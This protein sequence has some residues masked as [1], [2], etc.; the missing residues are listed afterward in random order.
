MFSTYQ[1]LEM[2]A[3]IQMLQDIAIIENNKI[4]FNNLEESNDINYIKHLLEVTD[5]ALVII[6]RYERAPL[7]IFNNYFPLLEIVSKKGVLSSLELYETIRLNQTIKENKRLLDILKKE[8]IA[9]QY[10]EKLVDSLYLIT[11]LDERLNKSIDEDG[12]VL[13]DAS[14]LLKSIRNKLKNIDNKIRTKLNEILARDTKK[15]SE[16]IV[17]LRNDRYCLAVKAEYKN[18]FKGIV[19]DVSGSLQTIYIEPDAVVEL[20]MEK[21]R[22]IQ[23]EKMEIERILRSLSNE[24]GDNHLILENNFKI[25]LEIDNI[26]SRAL[27]AKKM[28]ASKQNIN[29]EGRLNI[30]NARHPLLK[31]KKVIPNNISFSEK[32]HGIIITGPNTG[33]KT[34]LLKTVGLLSL[35]TKYGL[36]IPADSSSDIMIFDQIFCD[37]GDD[38]S[39]ENNLSTF[40]SHMTNIVSIVNQVS[41][42]SLV[43]I[44]EIG[45]GTDPIEGSNLAISILKYFIDNSITFITTTHYSSLKAFAFETDKIVNAS[46]EFDDKTLEPTYKL[47]L[48]ISGSSNAFNI[49]TRLGLKK[50]IVDNA[51]KLTLTSSDNIRPIILKLENQMKQVVEEKQ[52]LKEEVRKTNDLN[53]KLELE[54]NNISI[55][56]EK[57]ILKANEEAEKIIKDTKL[58]ALKIIDKLKLMEKRETKLHEIIEVKQDLKK[59]DENKIEIKK[60]N[61][62][63]NDIINVNDDVYIKDYDQYGV[64]TKILK[65]ETFLVSMG[66]IVAKFSK[67]ELKL[68]NLK[69]NSSANLSKS[70]SFKKSN[71]KLTLDLRGCRYEEAKD[72][73]DEYIDD[74]VCSNILQATIIHGYGTGVIRELVQSYLKKSPHI[75]T[76]RYGGEGEGG[77]GVTVITLKQG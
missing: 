59:I 6:N 19:H 12:F 71:V 3:I 9:C 35:M 76:F 68:V 51:K 53:K 11:S 47:K 24:M 55:E 29:T 14:S 73:L 52:K 56:K 63:N 1:K 20:T 54:Y 25:I 13:D 49:A 21:E 72:K 40:S 17:T 65:N 8:Q 22:L 26:F 43:L 77:F 38:Q 70:V 5:E 61:E 48:G 4:A 57:I 23:E 67:N 31:V 42:N 7:Y 60:K 39:I 50:E 28:N 69:T 2:N 16:T 74:L 58:D 36:L 46:M 15:L 64:V 18:T 75:D 37:V 62:D 34:V 27:L 44:D 32:Y 10:Y 30:V 33:G 66:N 45:S 41:P